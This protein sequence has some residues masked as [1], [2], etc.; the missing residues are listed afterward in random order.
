MWEEPDMI[1]T[2]LAVIFKHW[3]YSMV[4]VDIVT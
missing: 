3:T 2:R 1:H 4:F